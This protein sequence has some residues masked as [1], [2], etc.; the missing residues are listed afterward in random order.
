MSKEILNRTE[1]EWK[2]LIAQYESRSVTCAYFCKL[3]Q[4]TKG[5]V[6]KW[7]QHFLSQEELI[8]E[9]S[10][11]I[12]LVIHNDQES[13]KENLS[14]ITSEIR[15]SSSSGVVIEFIFG[16]RYLE[17]KAIMEILHATK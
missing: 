16:C 9:K 12:P 6:Y 4:V 11:F 15:I 10:A 8:S 3:H 17:L 1:A 7:R 14:N 5:Q 13:D 2:T